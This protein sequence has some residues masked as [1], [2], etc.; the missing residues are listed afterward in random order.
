[1]P[2]VMVHE[3]IKEGLFVTKMS[4]MLDPLVGASKIRLRPL[5]LRNSKIYT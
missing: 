2:A 5:L 1:M 3:S 4:N